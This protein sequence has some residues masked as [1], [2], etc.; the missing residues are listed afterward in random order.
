MKEQSANISLGR[1]K[2]AKFDE[3]YTTLETVEKELRHYQSHFKDK[4][5]FLN[6]DDPYESAFFQYFAMNFDHL[7]LKKLISV[8]YAGSSIVG[9]QLSLFDMAGLEDDPPPREPYKVE[10]TE[11]PDL[12]QDGA[13]DLVDVEELLKHNANAATKL[14]GDGDFRSPESIELLEE[15]DIVVTNPPFSLFRE[16]IA[17]LVEHDKDFLVIGNQ[18]AITYKEIFPLLQEGKVWLGVNHGDMEFRVPDY[19]EPRKTRFW[20][21]EDGQKWRSLG[22]ACWFTNLDHSR[23]HEEI[24]LFRKYEEDPS[25][26]PKYDNYDAIEVGRVA[27]IPI[28]WDGMMGV[29]ITFLGRHNPDQFEILGITKTWDDARGLKVRE[30]PRQTQVSSGGKRTSVTKLNDGPAIAVDERPQGTHYEVD[31]DFYIQTYA[32]ILVRRKQD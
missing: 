4:T 22:N 12:N 17:Q 14:E 8:S 1:A 30:Y 24:P 19:S 7:G 27:N 26:F 10:I 31:G 32:R 29:P 18:N 15:A 28:D 5:V 25:Q 23:R 6:C 11:V 9:D 13:I 16:Y 20:I 2:K 21:D 3:F